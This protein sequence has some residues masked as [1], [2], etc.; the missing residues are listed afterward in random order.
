MN[1]IN[2]N[3]SIFGYVRLRRNRRVDRYSSR[4]KV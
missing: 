4:C 1:L 3:K 2:Y